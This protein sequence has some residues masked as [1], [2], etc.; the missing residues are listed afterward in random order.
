MRAIAS[1]A[2]TVTSQR[3]PTVDIDTGAG[4][5]AL[6]TVPSGAVIRMQ[7]LSPSFQ[8]M[9]PWQRKLKSGTAAPPTV[10]GQVLLTAASTCGEEPVKSKWRVSCSLLRRSATR[11]ILSDPTRSPSI[12]ALP[13][14][15]P[16][17][18]SAIAS[19]IWASATFIAPSITTRTVSAPCSARRS[20]IR[21][22][23][24]SIAPIC[25]PR[26]SRTMSGRRELVT[27]VCSTSGDGTPS[28]TIF[29][30]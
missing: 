13:V 30:K 23:A 7:R 28:S 11:W 22:L 16:S 1:A 27:K 3:N 18:R 6:T 25:A 19:R 24:R 29:R 21:R 4:K 12:Q 5:R 10:A 9:S 20:S 17:G 2:A 8:S 14:Q 26:S 15:L